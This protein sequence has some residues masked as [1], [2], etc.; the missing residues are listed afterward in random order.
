[1][2]NFIGK[3]KISY[4]VSGLLFITAVAGLIVYG[5]KP[6]M[7]FTGGSI[8]EVSFT[9]QRPEVSAVR[10][11]VEGLFG[12]AVVQT[13]GD[14]GMIVKTRFLSEEEH[15]TLL[16]NLRT[17]YEKEDQKVL[18]QRFET[19]GPAVSAQ[20]K[21]RSAK[22]IVTVC[23]AIILFIAYSFRK[24]S[25]LVASWKYGVVAVVALVHDVVVT[26][27]IFA[28]LGKYMNIEVDVPFVV[29]LLTILGYSVN[30]TIVVFDRVRENLIRRGSEHF[31]ETV[32]YAVNETM[33]RSVNTTL[34]TLFPLATLFFFGGE[35]I[36][37]FSLALFI[38][39]FLGAYSSI[40][41]AS[42]LLVSW[43]KFS[44][45]R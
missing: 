38:G 17:N 14:A 8:L 44:S 28:F 13:S 26:A 24:V 45:R 23:I 27:G 7:D 9:G 12:N 10:M 22:A 2:I 34:T 37:Y 40:F 19:I 25:K 39:I 18:E 15:Q 21:E 20:L 29:A 33:A 16:G 42:P 3:R 36:K 6:G 31:D 35:T 5:L 11:S 43:H 32:N 4:I 41:V 30:D 1:M